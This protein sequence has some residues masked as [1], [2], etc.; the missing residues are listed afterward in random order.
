MP[1]YGNNQSLEDEFSSSCP[2]TNFFLYIYK[3]M[4]SKKDKQ[5]YL[6][7][8]ITLK[9]TYICSSGSNSVRE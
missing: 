5:G 7:C 2:N 8:S 6:N 4:C 3:Y 1:R 9:K